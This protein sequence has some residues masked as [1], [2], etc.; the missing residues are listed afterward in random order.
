MPLANSALYA[1]QCVC[2]V[3]GC[4]H[5]AYCATSAVDHFD[6]YDRAVDHVAEGGMSFS[7]QAP[8]DHHLV[9]ADSGF[10]DANGFDLHPARGVPMEFQRAIIV[11]RHPE[12]DDGDDTRARDLAIAAGM[13]ADSK[14]CPNYQY[15]YTVDD[16]LTE[17]ENAGWETW[18]DLMPFDPVNN[19]R[20]R[21]H[22]LFRPREERAQAAEE[23]AALRQR[24]Q[25]ELSV[26]GYL[27][28]MR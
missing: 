9:V 7:Q 17:F 25:N 28:H 16:V 4:T 8:V 15:G 13:A 22:M 12:D 5:S 11:E 2:G 19:R 18:R 3:D 14:L 10:L 26:S 24:L 21:V 23:Q 6:L 20:H 1:V 27:M